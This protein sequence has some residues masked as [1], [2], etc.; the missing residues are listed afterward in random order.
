MKCKSFLFTFPIHTHL[1]NIHIFSRW[2]KLRSYHIYVFCV[3][4]V[5][6]SATF[7]LL[8]NSNKIKGMTSIVFQSKILKFNLY[9]RFFSLTYIY[10][11]HAKFDSILKSF[12]FSLKKAYRQRTKQKSWVL[13]VP[14]TCVHNDT[15]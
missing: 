12:N 4:C 10:Q 3:L 13:V 8:N 14:E 15:W 11:L 5:N 1:S 6:T 9:F 7:P 2:W